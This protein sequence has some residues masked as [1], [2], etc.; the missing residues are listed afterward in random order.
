MKIVTASLVLV[1]VLLTCVNAQFHID[2]LAQAPAISFPVALAFPPDGCNKLLFT[3]KNSGRVRIIQNDSLL[4]EPFVTVSVK[5]YGEQGLLGVT[6]HPEYPDSPFVYIY[7][8]RTPDSANVLVRYTDSSGVGISPHELLIIPRQ[9]NAASHNGGNIHFGPDDKLYVTVGDYYYSFNA[10]D[11][12]RSNQR[13]KIHRFNADGTI[14]ADNP[15]PGNSIYAYG[16]RNSFDFTFDNL[17]GNMYASE[18]GPGCND[19]INFIV[20]G[21]NYGWP[22]N[23][24]CQYSDLPQY[25]NPMYY[26]SLPPSV[27]GIAVYRDTVF[28]EL[29]GK[30]IVGSFNFGKL[31]QFGLNATGD[32]IIAGPHNLAFIGSSVI[33]VEVGPDG[34]LYLANATYGGISRILR[35]R[36]AVNVPAS[37]QLYS[38]SANAVNQSV[39]PTFKWRQSAEAHHYDFQLA[40]DSD[41]TSIVYDT[42]TTVDTSVVAQLLSYATQYF[43]R[44][45]A[46][47]DIGTSSFSEIRTFT[48]THQ[49]PIAPLLESPG[50]SAQN[51]P[52][53]VTFRW[54]QAAHTSVYILNIAASPAFSPILFKDSTLTDTFR[55]VSLLGAATTYYWRVNARNAG[56]TSPYSE[57]RNFTTVPPLPGTIALSSPPDNSIGQPTEITLQWDSTGYADSYDVQVSADSL[58]GSIVHEDSAIALHSFTIDSL[59]YGIEY[60][61]HVRA[62]NIS[63][64]GGWSATWRFKTVNLFYPV[65]RNWNMISLP[66]EYAGATREEL[67]PTS[68]SS[69]FD[70]RKGRGYGIVDTVV[71]GTGYWVKFDSAGEF[72]SPGRIIHSDTIDIE[73]GWN[74]I[75]SISDTVLTGSIQTIPSGIIA[76][77]FF[78][79]ENEYIESNAIIPGKGYWVKAIVS[80]KILVSAD[81]RV[82][83]KSM[84]LKRK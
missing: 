63:G 19:E 29:Y 53:T 52:R 4:E 75:G 15:F 43:W 10:Q 84:I 45:R 77:S 27:T 64:I 68:A 22:W 54:R 23:G 79:F 60:Y 66:Q 17:T 73:S 6:F 35:L 1:L 74:L 49:A 62:R 16:C 80:G 83:A 30:L 59:L 51:Q 47:N 2:T 82:S 5:T 65:S 78:G 44:V 57:V 38:P 46:R 26:W 71:Q 41:F 70:F 34:N 20:A 8:T 48:T 36:R 25:K 3:E 58:F 21:K 24:Y 7:Y 61:W 55:T 56:G 67:F 50:D 81:S 39:Q 18:N 9:I 72:A 40:T 42:T 33:D 13:G 14:P 12:S 76:S 37:P 28:P 31:Y 32:S 69:L 11:T